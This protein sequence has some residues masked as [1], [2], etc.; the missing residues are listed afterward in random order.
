[1]NR[2]ETAMSTFLFYG[3]L[4]RMSGQAM[5]EPWARYATDPDI[6]RQTLARLVS[7]KEPDLISRGV[8]IFRDMFRDV[9]KGTHVV[10]L[11]GG[12]DSRSILGGLLEAGLKNDIVAVTYGTPGSLDYEIPAVICKETG[13]RHERIDLTQID[14]RPLCEDVSIDPGQWVFF[15]AAYRTLIIKKFGPDAIY[16]SGFMGGQV[17]GFHSLRV[18]SESWDNACAEFVHH[19]QFVRSVRLWNPDFR[20]DAVLPAQPI[21]SRELLNFDDQL[22][23]AIRQLSYV[24]PIVIQDAYHWQ[25]PLLF[26]DWVYFMLSVPYEL[27]ARSFLYRKILLA[28]YPGLYALPTRNDRGLTISSPG[29]LVLV[30]KALLSRGLRK[31]AAILAAVVSRRTGGFRCKSPLVNYIDF[32]D[33]LRTREDIR[34]FISACIFDLRDRQALPWLDLERLWHRHMSRRDNYGDVLFLLAA[35]E[36]NLRRSQGRVPNLEIRPARTCPPSG[37]PM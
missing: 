14:L 18:A 19:N 11:S 13:V 12:L 8:A 31:G 4:P 30:Q 6:R 34:D 17:A 36:W 23:F 10:P 7:E 29:W 24:K 5:D 16:W 32:D 22:D 37:P 15:D 9:P 3:Y 26:A 25:A 2:E 27:R 35:L 1:M 33:S 28:S 21:F 20:P